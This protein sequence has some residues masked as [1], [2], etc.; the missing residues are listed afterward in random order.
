MFTRSRCARRASPPRLN[1]ERL[2]DRVVP[3]GLVLPGGL[4]GTALDSP[5]AVSP[6]PD[7]PSHDLSQANHPAGD[8]L[9]RSSD[10]GTLDGQA[11]DHGPS[12]NTGHDKESW[13]GPW[14]DHQNDPGG[15]GASGQS[16]SS[17]ILAR[18]DHGRGPASDHGQASS[19]GT[20]NK[21]DGTTAR[22][23]RDI[24]VR[25]RSATA[26]QG[27][28]SDDN[29]TSGEIL[30]RRTHRDISSDDASDRAT[31]SS[32]SET[33]PAAAPAEAP[34]P[35]PAEGSVGPGSP[36]EPAAGRRMTADIGPVPAAAPPADAGS[37][38]PAPSRPA[39][40]VVP[41][42]LPDRPAAAQE[43]ADNTAGAAH[44]AAQAA[45]SEAVLAALD[46]RSAAPAALHSQ[47]GPADDALAAPLAGSVAL[48]P[49]GTPAE[50][51]AVEGEAPAAAPAAYA[52][53]AA[54]PAPFA[55]ALLERLSADTGALDAALQGFLR[56]LERFGEHLSDPGTRLGVSGWLL[57]GAAALAVLELHRR[58]RAAAAGADDVPLSWLDP[59]GPAPESAT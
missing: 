4:S 23:G 28:S 47:A 39:A 57:T 50:P 34:A 7:G 20:D 37:S 49:G 11:Q 40:P 6:A 41:L 8:V 45:G 1:V 10:A 21:E 53:F 42:R 2:E 25:D 5:M 33:A 35:A 19:D 55:G 16:S 54:Q 30:G 13:A 31:A 36:E 56:G 59:E 52:G 46:A 24:Y 44:A 29:S 26:R 58:R 14:Q 32:A 17:S 9:S 51:A 12:A 18:D 27:D 3:H 48:A 22:R 38:A 15:N 43:E